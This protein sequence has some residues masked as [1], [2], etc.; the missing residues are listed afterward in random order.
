MSSI[1]QD[2]ILDHYRFPRNFGTIENPSNSVDVSNP[3][4]GDKLHIDIK[5]KDSKIEEISFSGEG[6]A[7]SIA[8]ASM[9]TEYAKGK[10]KDE[11]KKIESDFILKEL[12]Q[13]QLTPNRVKCAL[14]SWEAL[15]KVLSK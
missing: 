9:L 13:I 8:S 10:P 4:C 15:V 3:L 14:L 6:C 2:I 5:E 12:L 11:L 7:I 1:Y